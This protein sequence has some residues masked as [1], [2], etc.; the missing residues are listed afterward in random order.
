[1]DLHITIVLLLIFITGG[2]SH[3][4][5]VC[6]PEGNSGACEEKQVTCPDG[7]NKCYSSTETGFNDLSRSVT[8]KTCAKICETK[9]LA[10]RGGGTISVK[11]CDTDLCI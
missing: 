7:F 11:C 8:F 9:T 2:L 10:K 1:M 6:E 4:C 3:R 5:Y